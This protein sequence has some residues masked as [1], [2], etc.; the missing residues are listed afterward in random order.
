MNI[1][2]RRGRPSQPVYGV[3]LEATSRSASRPTLAG[4]RGMGPVRVGNQAYVH[5]QHD[6]YGSLVLAAT[7]SFFD[8]AP[9]AP[10]APRFAQLERVG[11]QALRAGTRRTR[12]LGAA[13]ARARAHVLGLMCWAACDRLAKI[14]RAPRRARARRSGAKRP[15]DPRARSWRAL[16]R[17]R[18]SF[19]AS[20]G[21]E[22]LDATLLLL[23][24]LGFLPPTTRASP[25]PSP[26]SRRSCRGPYLFRYAA[27]DDFG[28]PDRLQHLH[29]L[30]HRRARRS[31]GAARRASF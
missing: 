6:V 27:P 26:R 14:A 9:A 10:G 17:A 2:A 1:V 5:P 24:E 30:V 20:F 29:V 11:E 21:G 28:A 15:R 19:V 25:A 3:A 23:N 13:H 8:R 31:A 4:Y 16:E 18:G 12:G 22:R 7:H